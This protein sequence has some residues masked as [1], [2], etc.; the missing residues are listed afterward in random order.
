VLLP[1]LISGRR[2]KFQNFA[3]DVTKHFEGFGLE[4][5]SKGNRRRDNVLSKEGR[6]SAF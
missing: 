6:K 1:P 4:M 2:L 3:V 5:A